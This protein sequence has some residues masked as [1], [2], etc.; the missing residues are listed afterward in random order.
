MKKWI[1]VFV[2]FAFMGI[3][4]Q[5]VT[6]FQ[7]KDIENTSRDFSELKGEKLTLIDFWTTWCKPCNKAI[8]ELNKIYA[9]Y[10]DKGVAI[11]GI[12]CD[13]PRS[14]AK[15]APLSK[16]LQIQYPILLDIDSEIKNRLNL[17]AFPT[18]ILVNSKGKI[19]WIHEGFV[20]GDAELII[21]ELERNLNA[22]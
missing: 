13:G 3:Q 18:L 5:T 2:T 6:D 7:L 15:V 9:T 4:A 14:I 16:S 21:N 17:M 19:I 22:N 8:P 1:A 20:S 12:S 11:I 10:K